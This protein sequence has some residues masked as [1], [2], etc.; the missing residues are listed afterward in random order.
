M[1]TALARHNSKKFSIVTVIFFKLFSNVFFLQYQFL[2]LFFEVDCS[3]FKLLAPKAVTVRFPARCGIR[4]SDVR[5]W[6][7]VVFSPASAVAERVTVFFFVMSCCNG[8][9]VADADVAA[10]D[11]N[12]TWRFFGLIFSFGILKFKKKNT[13]EN[14]EYSHPECGR[15]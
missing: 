4:L 10:C 11:A 14:P 1:V 7:R 8:E 2:L 15:L 9:P 13:Y 6:R 5:R 3:F 12:R